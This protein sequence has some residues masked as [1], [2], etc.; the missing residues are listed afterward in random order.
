[1]L[2][3][4][5][6]TGGHTRLA[7][8]W[9]RQ[10]RQRRHDVVL[11]D[12]TGVV[13]LELVQAT[14]STGGRV[15]DLTLMRGGYIRQAAELVDAARPADVVVLHHHP[16]DVVPAFTFAGMEARPPVI[17]VNHAGRVF[18]AGAGAADVVAWLR[19]ATR[20]LLVPRRGVPASRLAYLPTPLD[21]PVDAA[22]AGE[23]RRRVRDEFGIPRDA[24]CLVTVASERKY[25]AVDG[26]SLPMILAEYMAQR[27]EVH[28]LAVGPRL[29]DDWARASHATE[30][31]IRALGPRSP[32]GPLLAAA[33]VAV[34]SFPL[35]SE[36][37][38]REAGLMGL[39]ILSFTRFRAVAPAS[40]IDLPGSADDFILRA[41]DE[42]AFGAVL[43][44][45]VG[46]HGRRRELGTALRQAI[47]DEAYGT[48]WVT[49]LDALYERALAATPMSAEEL[50]EPERR[51]DAL[52]AIVLSSEVSGWKEATVR[53][54]ERGLL[55]DRQ[56]RA[57]FGARSPMTNRVRRVGGEAMR[58]VRRAI[59][60]LRQH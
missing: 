33:D 43:T 7:W 21:P 45:L 36:T 11:L 35:S 23:L 17:L 20:D 60:S 34:D 16:F 13:P 28:L 59:A 31:H 48:R 58:V 10:D 40:A 39:P 2:T 30:G 54:A 27:P 26:R 53:D 4:A 44:E 1:V 25:R 12:Q 47:A 42:A 41:D 19:P 52:D 38:V 5:Q 18:A 9:I 14:R 3:D 8:R 32:T 37:A 46:D 49:H 50:S 51:F 55:G 6:P 57:P 22:R 15:T 56:T 24:V 29:R